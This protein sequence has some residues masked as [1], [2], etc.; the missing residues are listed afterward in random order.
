[1]FNCICGVV[2]ISSESLSRTSYNTGKRY[3]SDSA[4]ND[5][6]IPPERNYSKPAANKKSTS[7]LNKP[8][9]KNVRC[10]PN[11]F[12][13]CPMFSVCQNKARSNY[14]NK[15]IL[16][17]K[18]ENQPT[19]INYTG[20]VLRQDDL[21]VFLELL[22]YA[23][24]KDISV[25]LE[26]KRSK[27]LNALGWPQKTHYYKKL[28][29]C[30]R[31]LLN[32]NID[33]FITRK[34]YDGVNEKYDFNFNLIESLECEHSSRLICYRLPIGLE[35]FYQSS[36]YTRIKIEHRRVLKSNIAKW[37]HLYHRS[38]QKNNKYA[39]SIETAM[40]ICGS[41]A[42]SVKTF[43]QSLNKNLDCLKSFNIDL[44]IDKDSDRLKYK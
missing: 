10:I 15:T 43:R 31:R 40:K 37:M 19:K 12:I 36:C 25:M 4:S 35:V 16:E 17:S 44:Y 34:N 33:G 23:R 1:M 39:M 41:K 2:I 14:K 7:L 13:R 3:L 22:H 42:K 18:P 28:D 38:H 32:A 5:D 11:E 24:D 29:A 9:A 20:R 27:L 26:I 8:W 6:S 21:D 30:L